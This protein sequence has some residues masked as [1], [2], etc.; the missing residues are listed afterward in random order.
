MLQKNNNA[1][2]VMRCALGVKPVG[3]RIW[4]KWRCLD[5]KPTQPKV[6]SVF[7]VF[8]EL[9]VLG[10][11]PIKCNKSRRNYSTFSFI[12]LRAKRLHCRHPVHLMVYPT[13]IYLITYQE[14]RRK[15]YEILPA[16]KTVGTKPGT[17]GGLECRP[18]LF[19]HGFCATV[20]SA[21]K[22]SYFL[23]RFSW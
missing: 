15:K 9:A 14:N 21:R 7:E 10:G 22:I 13:V 20:L 18:P 4:R 5:R 12:I 3:L 11:P 8:V 23:R 16:D 1:H 17:K 19:V 2:T 6:K